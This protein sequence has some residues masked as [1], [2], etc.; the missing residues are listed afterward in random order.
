MVTCGL[1]VGNL[2]PPQPLSGEFRK[3]TFSGIRG[4]ARYEI[5]ELT[6]PEFHLRNDPFF[7]YRKTLVF[8]FYIASEASEKILELFHRGK[9]FV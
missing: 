1:A 2:A 7:S 9:K 4:G 8:G 6:V 5:P 3:M